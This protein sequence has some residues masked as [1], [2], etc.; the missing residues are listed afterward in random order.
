[1]KK[2]LIVTYHWYPAGGPGVQRI[3]KFAK[4]LNKFGWKPIILT[5][6][7]GEYPALD[8]SLKKNIPEDIVEYRTKSLE[9]NFLYKKFMGMKPE[10]KIPTAI[11][12]DDNPSLK[13]KITAW[14]R[15]N[16][17][18]PDAK[19][20]WLPF[21]VNEGKKII[22]EEKPDIIFST[23][24]PPTVHI[25]AQKL[26]DSSKLP[27]IADFRDPW[28]DIH[29]YEKQPRLSVVKKFDRALEKKVLNK[30]DK[31]VC[32]SKLDI[33]LDFG[34]KVSPTKCIN[35]PN[36][37]DEEDF[38]NLNLNYNHKKFILLHLGA[39]NKERNPVSLFKGIKNL[40]QKKIITPE[41]FMLKFVGNVENIVTKTIEDLD[42]GNYIEIIPYKPH[43]EALSYIEDASVMLLLI[44][45]SE[46]NK[47]I[48]P[49]KTFEYLRTLKFIIAL[50]PTDG[51]VANIINNT[52]SGIVLDYSNES[53]IEETLE[54]Q[55][56]KWKQKDFHNNNI[57][58]IEKYKREN[59]TEE[60]INLF[61]SVI[62]EK[63]KK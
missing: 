34:K 48:L 30:A 53:K 8:F 60:L 17:F 56:I 44:T 50:G 49:G 5:V 6:A 62:D 32:I 61:D 27:W 55:I 18:I 1:M 20:G 24:P 10:Q 21:A 14:I 43:K 59:L 2:A 23:S 31:V 47:R 57:T 3:L 45:R 9:P 37:Y 11:L 52:N 19:I 33:T 29:Y 4:Y 25:I 13:K 42:I 7:K 41:N 39:I 26:A 38:E 35:I 51:E 54:A 46:K 36:G 22:R 15:L 16:F 12:V 63:Y 28:T 58:N 40:A